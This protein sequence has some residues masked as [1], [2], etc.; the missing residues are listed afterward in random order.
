MSGTQINIHVDIGKASQMLANLQQKQ[1]PYVIAATV[2]NLAFRVVQAERANMQRRTAT[3]STTGLSVNSARRSS[4]TVR[5]CGSAFLSA[6][7]KR[8]FF[9]IHG[10][11]AVADR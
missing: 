2:N 4:R 3:G 11:R 8:W 10:C 1:L 9:A 5:D 7:N 6:I